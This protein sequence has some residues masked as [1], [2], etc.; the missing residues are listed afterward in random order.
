MYNLDTLD[1]FG[2][3]YPNVIF[4]VP[5]LKVEDGEIDGLE[6]GFS[7]EFM[8]YAGFRAT[9]NEKSEWEAEPCCGCGNSLED[10]ALDPGIFALVQTI[11]H[12]KTRLH[13]IE[14]V[15]KEETPS[16]PA[17]NDARPGA[18]GSDQELFHDRLYGSVK[19]QWIILD[20]QVL[21]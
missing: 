19:E 5:V 4:S 11:D 12:H 21:G 8:H 16:N 17:R 9:D 1:L 13:P 15:S 18:E 2:D 6:Y 7:I 10:I 20:M 3:T 14:E